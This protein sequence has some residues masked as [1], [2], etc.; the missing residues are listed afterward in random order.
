MDGW[1]GDVGNYALAVGTL[2][3]II[4]SD[5][6]D[7]D[8][9]LEIRFSEDMYTNA[10][11]EGAVEP[12]DFEIL[13]DQ[14]TGTATG[15]SLE[16]LADNDGNPLLSGEDTIR[17]YITVIGESTGQELITIRTQD[18]ASIFN[19][20]GMGMKKSASIT[21]GLSDST[22]PEVVDTNFP[23]VSESL[24]LD[25]EIEIFLSEPLY[26]VE[27]NELLDS[28]DL[29]DFITLKYGD[30][31]GTDIPFEVQL[32]SNNTMIKI[33]PTGVFLSDETVYFNFSG[34]FGDGK[35]NSLESRM[36]F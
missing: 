15:I 35:G 10:T 2:P 22:P 14:S 19:S 8:S 4:S 33:V 20:F 3:E 32:D 1:S 24:A 12:S 34:L 21:Q 30:S 9:Y 7:D 13:F 17:F 36:V 23:D 6:A 25:S 18:N 29:L 5:I 16:Y 26:S 27:T 11:G 28:S 31:L